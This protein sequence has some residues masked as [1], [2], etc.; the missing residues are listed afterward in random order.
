MKYRKK[1]IVIEAWQWLFNDHQEKP[2]SWV[3]DALWKWPD[4]GGISFEPDS[5]SGPRIRIATLDAVAVALPG[6]WIIK[7]IKGELYP[8]KADIFDATYEVV[9]EN[10]SQVNKYK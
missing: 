7:G 6:D 9:N 10:D 5:T 8:C 2:P 3:D 4:I 1:L